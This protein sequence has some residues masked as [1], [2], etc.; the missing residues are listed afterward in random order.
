MKKIIFPLVCIVLLIVFFLGFIDIDKSVES[1]D[2]EGIVY[3]MGDIPTELSK[4]T[5]LSK[6]DEDIICATSRGLV[7]KDLDGKIKPSLAKEIN[8]RDNGIEYEFVLRDDIYWSNGKK[9]KPEE[10]GSFFKE[11]IKI[12]DEENIE[13][14]LSIYGA[15]EFKAGTGT[16]EGGVA[17][18]TTENSIKMRLNKP[19]D[20]FVEDLTKPQ[21]RLRTYLPLWDEIEENYSTIVYSGDYAITLADKDKIEIN[22]NKYNVGNG[23]SKITFTENH[24]EEVAMASFEVGDTDVVLNPPS[25]QL[26]RLYSENR[27]ISSPSNSGMYIVFNSEKETLP[28][29][30]RRELFKIISEAAEGY[31][32]DNSK[33]VEVAEGSYFRSDK[34]DLSKLQTRKVSI[35]EEGD[36]EGTGT[37]SLLAEDNEINRE[38]CK[39]LSE[40]FEK[41]EDQVFKYTLVESEELNDMELRKRYDMIIVA[42]EGDSNNKEEFYSGLDSYLTV[43]QKN[44]LESNLNSDKNKYSEL[45]NEL[46]NSYTILPVLYQNTNIAISSNIQTMKFDGN[47]NVDFSNI[48]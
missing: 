29:Q 7:E 33:R 30:G 24:N 8:V 1:V 11:L 26:N 20:K 48:N 40:W 37:V 13:A 6:R 42:A 16:F 44:I 27:L 10:I 41:N 36:W 17:I 47:G 12:E 2:A 34:D 39:Y 32:V 15:K 45:E 9:I 21:Y 19:N 18:S 31:G 46:F 38:F 22:K 4:I 25:S 28:M 23:V 5:S 35:N 43:K 14:A 3:S